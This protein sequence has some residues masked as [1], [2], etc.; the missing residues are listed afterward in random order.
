MSCGWFCPF[1]GKQ[2]EKKTTVRYVKLEMLM[3]SCARACPDISHLPAL[4]I[5]VRPCLF[6]YCG[7]GSLPCATSPLWHVPA[8]SHASPY[9]LSSSCHSLELIKRTQKSVPFVRML[10]EEEGKCPKPCACFVSVSVLLSFFHDVY[11]CARTYTPV[12][13]PHSLVAPYPW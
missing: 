8:C 11:L 13:H 12:M 9:A 2:R 6:R 1:V 7:H 3:A 10:S 5:F 4:F